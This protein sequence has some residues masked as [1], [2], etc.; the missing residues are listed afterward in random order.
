[1]RGTLELPPFSAGPSG[2][3]RERKRWPSIPTDSHWP[4]WPQHSSSGLVGGRRSQAEHAQASGDWSL[5]ILG[6]S[7]LGCSQQISPEYWAAEPGR[8]TAITSLVPVLRL[9]SEEHDVLSKAA[10]AVRGAV[11]TQ[12][13]GQSQSHVHPAAWSN[14]F[15]HLPALCHCLGWAELCVC[16]GGMARREVDRH[17]SQRSLISKSTLPSIRCTDLTNKYEDIQR[18]EG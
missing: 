4:T 11:I 10:P 14:G 6:L 1:M 9:I 5:P 18:E 3:L 17:N 13:G 8:R 7:W 16:T 2:H 12:G 15:G